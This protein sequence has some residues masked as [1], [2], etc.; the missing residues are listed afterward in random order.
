MKNLTLLL[1]SLL[2]L[3][4]CSGNKDTKSLIENF[5][6]ERDLVA[7]EIPIV[8]DMGLQYYREIQSAGDYIIGKSF[9]TRDF[10][11]SVL[12]V[13]NGESVNKLIP[14]G[15]G[16]NEAIHVYTSSNRKGEFGY[17]S[18]TDSQVRTMNSDDLL[19]SNSDIEFNR[20]RFSKDDDFKY[21]L[22]NKIRLENGN[23]LC[24]GYNPKDDTIL[25]VTDSEGAP[26][27]SFGSLPIKD[28]LDV[29]ARQTLQCATAMSGDNL[30]WST[31]GKGNIYRFYDYSDLSQE[32]KLIK[33]YFYDM[34][35]FIVERDE[36]GVTVYPAPDSPIGA[37]NIA[38]SNNNFFILF[39]APETNKENEN[40]V[41]MYSKVLVFTHQGEP[42]E[43]LNLNHPAR[44]IAYLEKTNSLYAFGE[45]GDD[46]LLLQYKLN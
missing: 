4:S 29:F 7:T 41:L 43:I 5:T 42:V 22:V 33:E 40:E 28:D 44:G 19:K 9:N 34:P 45:K 38:A 14:Y 17:Y 25:Q 35:K 20:H 36:Y 26:L 21:S 46:L 39:T 18:H 23:F 11:F 8:D 30:L 3:F 16:H 37:T 27:Y 31:R 2:S 15:R 6:K 24:S 13:T 1:L 10:H 32:P 12:D